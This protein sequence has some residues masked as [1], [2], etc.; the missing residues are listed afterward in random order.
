M[1]S[2]A[3]F[4]AG[5]RPGQMAV[6]SYRHRQ[7]TGCAASHQVKLAQTRIAVSYRDIEKFS[8][9][10]NTAAVCFSTQLSQL[11]V[12][13]WSELNDGLLTLAATECLVTSELN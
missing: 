4:S 5:E 11:P 6:D 13:Y 8:R 10:H 7:R 12:F 2:R 3:A 9:G 1:P